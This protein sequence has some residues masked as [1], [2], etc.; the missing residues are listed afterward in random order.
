MSPSAVGDFFVGRA[1]QVVE[2]VGRVTYDRPPQLAAYLPE[3][4]RIWISKNDHVFRLKGHDE[5]HFIASQRHKPPRLFL[6]IAG[7]LM[8]PSIKEGVPKKRRLVCQKNSRWIGV[9]SSKDRCR[10]GVFCGR[11]EDLGL[12]ARPGFAQTQI[13]DSNLARRPRASRHL[14]GW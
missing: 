5:V 6:G 13:P 2:S 3:C 11:R 9:E 1:L 10:G 7:K 8:T 12:S 4:V 14:R